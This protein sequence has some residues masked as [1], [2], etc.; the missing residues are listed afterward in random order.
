MGMTTQLQDHSVHV[1]PAR[2]HRFHFL[3]ALRGVASLMVVLYHA[4]PGLLPIVPRGGFLSVDLFFALSGFVIAYSYAERLQ[5]GLTFS[6]FMV[7]RLIRV[8]PVYLLGTLLALTLG[9]VV[10]RA[11]VSGSWGLQAAA[12]VLLIPNVLHTGSNAVYP[13]N[14]PSWSLLCE[15]IAYLCY[16]A[17]AR[18][19]SPIRRGIYAAVA[20]ASLLALASWTR[21]AGTVDGGSTMSTLRVGLERVGY[22]FF[23]G[24]LL[25]SVYKARV[26]ARLGAGLSTLLGAALLVVILLCLAAPVALSPVSQLAIVA[27]VL[28]AVVYA[29]ARVVTPSRLE[30]GAAFLGDMSYPL[31]LIHIPLFSLLRGGFMHGLVLHHTAEAHVL[32][33]VVV[34]SLALLAWAIARFVD[35]PVRKDLARRYRGR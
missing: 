35:L 5:Q 22:S 13:L 15:M 6:D 33:F 32:G 27:A 3:D 8:Y 31:Y 20:L 24:V 17:L 30:S 9:V 26:R 28:P 7:A 23:T 11:A 14:F 2:Q 10:N 25:Y 34:V 4:P 29:G 19:R 1:T 18:L 21:T 12:G 16:G